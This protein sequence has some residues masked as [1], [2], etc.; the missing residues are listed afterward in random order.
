[1]QTDEKSVEKMKLIVDVKA[2]FDWLEP[3]KDTADEVVRAQADILAGVAADRL[4]QAF[5]LLVAEFLSTESN[6]EL[7][8]GAAVRVE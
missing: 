8:G 3:P 6:A 4:K 7:T 1:M 5:H 2:R